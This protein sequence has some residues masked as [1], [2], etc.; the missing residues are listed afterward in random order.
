M[1]RLE[2][3]TVIYGLEANLCIDNIPMTLKFHAFLW[4]YKNFISYCTREYLEVETEFVF[5]APDFIRCLFKTAITIAPRLK[6]I[7]RTATNKNIF[8]KMYLNK[9]SIP[10][11]LLSAS[12]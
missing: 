6:Y 9:T 4:F 1:N 12:P 11:S 3:T 5:F 2:K 7:P 10:F 8:H